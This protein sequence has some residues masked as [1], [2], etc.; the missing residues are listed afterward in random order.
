MREYYVYI[1]TCRSYTTLYTGMTNDLGRRVAQHKLATLDG[2]TKKYRTTLLVYYDST[3]DVRDAI[4]REK[5]IKNL[6]RENKI[7]LIESVNPCWVD[8]SEALFPPS[9]P[10]STLRSE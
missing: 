5:W 7:A 2:F 9:P 1:M 4:D 3:N 6:S 8:L 10:G